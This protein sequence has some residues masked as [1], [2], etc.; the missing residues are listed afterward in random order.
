MTSRCFDDTLGGTA[1]SI[2]PVSRKSRRECGS[3]RRSI[4]Y[5]S[6]VLLTASPVTAHA[7][8]VEVGAFSDMAQRCAPSVAVLTLA[9]IAKTESGFQTLATFD[10]TIR[11]GRTYRSV[12]EA[13]PAVENLISNGHSM[14]LGLMQINS[15]NLRKLGM[16]VGDAFD[17]C[18]SIAGGASILAENFARA[19]D[20]AT[21]QIAL[22]DAVS[23][24]NTGNRKRGYLNGYVGKVERA[25]ANLLP[26]FANFVAAGAAATIGAAD[27]V[28]PSIAGDG[29]ADP[30][31]EPRWWDVWGV[32]ATLAPTAAA[33]K[34]SN[35]FVF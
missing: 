11:K 16:T 18:R 23:A 17:P 32:N 14:D 22:R 20:A 34:A 15:A 19:Q 35:V 26:V 25:A 7:H 31:V 3:V 30:N 24:Y 13:V 33:T 29:A 21:P 28:L 4:C 12:E 10:N 5:V 8:T 27:I 9:A 2:G 6:A 1:Q